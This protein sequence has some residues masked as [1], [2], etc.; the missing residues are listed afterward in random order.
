MFYCEPYAVNETVKSK[1]VSEGD[2]NFGKPKWVL[3]PSSW[4]IKKCSECQ[5]KGMI[6]GFGT[7]FSTSTKILKVFDSYGNSNL[8]WGNAPLK[9]FSKATQSGHFCDKCLSAFSKKLGIKCKRILPCS[10]CKK[11]APNFIAKPVHGESPIRDGSWIKVF[12]KNRK[13]M[14][15]LHN[16]VSNECNLRD[17]VTN[18]CKKGADTK[19]GKIQSKNLVEFENSNLFS[20]LEND[21]SSHPFDESCE[22]WS[23]SDKPIGKRPR[24]RGST[25][26]N[27]PFENKKPPRSSVESDCLEPAEN[28]PEPN[29]TEE[30]SLGIEKDL[31][32]KDSTIRKKYYTGAISA[33]GSQAITGSKCEI[34]VFG[35]FDCVTVK[36]KLM[37]LERPRLGNFQDIPSYVCT[38]LRHCLPIVINHATRK[39]NNRFYSYY[40]AVAYTSKTA[41]MSKSTEYPLDGRPVDYSPNVL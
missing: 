28:I 7:K 41:Y 13:Q 15:K 17:Y 27:S 10:G 23:M 22:S 12:P 26:A 19:L 4:N 11:P 30:Q 35:A 16:Y 38:K 40:L 37:T 29:P 34:Y 1:K 33:N 9:L 20:Y 31:K 3:V 25:H 18:E 32:P 14:N 39:E 2:K 36:E 5:H 8:I 24:K 21:N 6:V